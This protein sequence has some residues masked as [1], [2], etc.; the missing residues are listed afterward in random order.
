MFTTRTGLRPSDRNLRRIL[1]AAA[2][3]AG[4]VGVSHHT[5][6]HTHGS[7]LLDQGWT[8]PEI[9]KRLGHANPMITAEVYSHV[10]PDRSRD[11][12]FLD[13]VPAEMR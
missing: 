3:K 9:S 5:L 13:A 8:I 7:M 1:D 10:M 4:V 6:R 12:S 11:L 2:K